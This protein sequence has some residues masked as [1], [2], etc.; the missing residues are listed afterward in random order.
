MSKKRSPVGVRPRPI[1]I[2]V[3]DVFFERL[4][5][6]ARRTNA[7]LNYEITRLLQVALDMEKPRQTA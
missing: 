5:D 2:R 3:S 1:L 6:S 7:S 4:H